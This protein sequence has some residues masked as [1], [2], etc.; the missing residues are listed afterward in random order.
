MLKSSQTPKKTTP[1]N[2]GP[3]TP[4]KKKEGLSSQK[5]KQSNLKHHFS[6]LMPKSQGSQGGYKPK[7]Q[8]YTQKSETKIIKNIERE[9]TYKR[10]YASVF[11]E[12]CQPKQPKNGVSKEAA[13]DNLVNVLTEE[14]NM[15]PL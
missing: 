1:T 7:S 4:S 10:E 12:F 3:T 2:T 15:T 9:D 8:H 5:K 14:A 6:P 13:N 11:N